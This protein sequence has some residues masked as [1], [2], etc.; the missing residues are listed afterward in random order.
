MIDTVSSPLTQA[1][2]ELVECALRVLMKVSPVAWAEIPA[3][4]QRCFEKYMERDVWT[5]EPDFQTLPRAAVMVL[6][7][8]ISRRGE[9]ARTTPE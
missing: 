1:Q 6:R 8:A 7:D 9:F 2:M 3:D 5:G 4:L